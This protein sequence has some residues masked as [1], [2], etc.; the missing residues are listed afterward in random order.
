[1]NAWN[2]VGIAH[3]DGI[4]IKCHVLLSCLRYKQV[5]Q[6]IST[7]TKE[8]QMANYTLPE[9]SFDG[10]YNKQVATTKFIYCV[11]QNE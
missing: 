2:S 1:M 8:L 6:K 4:H 7:S 5:L 11:Y 3:F 9:A 10:N